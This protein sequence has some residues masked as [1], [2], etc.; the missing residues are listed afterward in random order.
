MNEL[1]T[2]CVKGSGHISIKPDQTIITLRFSDTQTKYEEA[3]SKA[4]SDVR[5]VKEKLTKLG[6]DPKNLKTTQF[7]VREDYD[8]YRDEKGKYQSIFVGY[9][10]NQTLVFSFGIDNEFLGKVLYEI[11]QIKTSPRF[12]I[13][14][15]IK[16]P[17]KAKNEL[18][19]NAV[20]DAQEK[21]KVLSNASSVDLKEIIKI[22]YSWGVIRFETDDYALRSQDFRCR[23]SL[24]VNG[25]IDVDIEPD[26]IEKNDIVTLIY[27]IE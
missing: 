26:D 27:R 18:L 19:A 3:V 5:D 2:L 12:E 7:D 21:A 16:D 20:K 22:D 15:G 9:Q 4:A 8:S 13:R 6:L 1:R 25:S 11:T 24:D 17:E 14:F 10:Y 23:N